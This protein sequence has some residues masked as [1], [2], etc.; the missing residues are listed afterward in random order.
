MVNKGNINEIAPH[1]PTP[2]TYRLL[3]KNIKIIPSQK[4]TENPHV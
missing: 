4:T 3:A 2:L 1:P